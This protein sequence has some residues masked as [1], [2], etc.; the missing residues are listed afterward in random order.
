MANGEWHDKRTQEDLQCGKKTYASRQGNPRRAWKKDDRRV[1]V[2][3]V[4]TSSSMLVVL[5]RRDG[6]VEVAV[7]ERTEGIVRG[8]KG[9]GKDERG[10]DEMR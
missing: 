1:T 10:N 7:V 5:E 3:K 4:I 2:E 8:D 6:P 9:Q